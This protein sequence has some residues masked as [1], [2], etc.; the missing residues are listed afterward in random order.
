M[1]I[2]IA[3]KFFYT[4]GGAEL[5]AI[6]TQRVLTEHGHQVRIFAMDYPEN[7]PLKEQDTFPLEVKPFGSPAD[8]IKA[9][10]RALGMGDVRAA[11][12]KALDEFKPDVVHAH[13]IHTYL[14][15]L[16]AEE[17]HKRGI[18]VVWTLHDYKPICPA[19]SF[20]RPDGTICEECIK[21]GSAIIKHHCMKDSLSA[22]VMAWIEARRWSR[23]RLNEIVDTFISPSAFLGRKLAEAGFDKNKIKVLCN[24]LDPDKLDALHNI[25]SSDRQPGDAEPY[26]C[27]I[28]RL[29]PEKGVGTM[30]QAAAMANVNIKVAGRGPLF[31]ELTSRYADN[32]NIQFLGHLDAKQVSRLLKGAV[33]SIMPSEC[34]ENNP[35]GVI[36]SLSAGTP[37]I[38]AEIGGIPEL[39][40]VG[41]DGF[42]YPSFNTDELVQMMLRTLKQPFDRKAIAER[43][44]LRF[45]A[46]THYDQLIRIYQGTD[47]QS[48]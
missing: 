20:R 3:S 4:R 6:N 19:Y 13:N 5:V 25:Q 15:P 38:G 10:R 33:A 12:R 29:S 14:S 16:I 9:A 48:I 11:V 18:R 35:L 31:E 22:S 43:A 42:T 46:Q 37:V 39:I 40:E 36:E 27:Y 30:L 28:G 32:A 2:L 45:C 44:A 24:F 41:K 21:H 17:A 8:K 34:Y 1:R 26:F 23:K 7:I 47:T